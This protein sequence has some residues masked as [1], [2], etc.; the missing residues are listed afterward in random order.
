MDDHVVAVHRFAQGIFKS[1]DVALRNSK[2][3]IGRVGRHV[4][5]SSGREVVVDSDAAGSALTEQPIDEVGTNEARPADDEEASARDRIGP[6]R[7]H[8]VDSHLVT[9][10]F[11]AG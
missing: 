10:R 2:T 6:R 8:F 3:R 9:L 11:S 5:F 4:P 1:S 7:S